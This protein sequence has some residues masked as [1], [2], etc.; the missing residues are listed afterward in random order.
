[1]DNQPP[2]VVSP[3]PTYSPPPVPAPAAP[4]KRGFG[5]LLRGLLYVLLLLVV[6]FGVYYWQHQK[7]N[8]LQKQVNNLKSQLHTAQANNQANS[9]STVGGNVSTKSDLRN[10]MRISDINAL[11]TQLEA[12]FSQNGYYPSLTD[13][14]SATWLSTNMKSLDPN[15]LADPSNSSGNKQFAAEPVANQYAYQV[16]DASGNSCES[17]DTACAKYTLTATYE[18]TVNGAHTFV[19]QNLD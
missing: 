11:Q 16:T 4:A 5:R 9:A 3:Q 15:T 19:K 12:F 13:M 14:N 6:A 7:V 10:S 2:V 1:M 17:K 8:N 18:G